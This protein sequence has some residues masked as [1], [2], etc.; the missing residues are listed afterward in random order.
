MR[1][2]DVDVLILGGGPAGATAAALL[3]RNRWRVRLV[4]R[5]EK[6]QP[7]LGESLPPSSL[8][9][10][11]RLGLS[12][13][14]DSPDHVRTAGLL[15]AWG[16]VDLIADDYLVHPHGGGLHVDRHSF[17]SMLLRRAVAAGADVRMGMRV[18]GIARGPQGWNVRFAGAR[19]CHAR[20]LV[21]ATGRRRA[22]LGKL[23]VGTVD[24]HDLFA[25]A[26]FLRDG[27]EGPGEWAVV[28]TVPNG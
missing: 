12:S 4:E 19:P 18:T 1:Q 5:R 7:S 23:G 24:E 11:V 26:A 9:V 28:E 25:L 21:D 22:L 17:D 13:V 14:I 2:L 16:D 10:L 20:V 27:S 15:S 8:S 6:L 3:A